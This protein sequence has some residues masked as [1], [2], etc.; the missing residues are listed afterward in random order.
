MGMCCHRDST[1]ILRTVRRHFLGTA[2]CLQCC[3]LQ[4]ELVMAPEMAWAREK[5]PESALESASEP[6]WA[7][8][9]LAMV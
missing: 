4:L 5:A 2:R 7:L 3:K 8:V 1:A 9:A 6:G